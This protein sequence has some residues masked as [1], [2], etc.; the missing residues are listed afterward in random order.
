MGTTKPWEREALRR[1]A[2]EVAGRPW[3]RRD[4][5]APASE[6]SSEGELAATMAGLEGGARRGQEREEG[7]EACLL[8]TPEGAEG[9]CI[10]GERALDMPAN[11]EHVAGRKVSTLVGHFWHVLFGFRSRSV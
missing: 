6:G 10:N 5:R 3:R 11:S 1:S 2:T 4:P 8:P 7:R 9:S